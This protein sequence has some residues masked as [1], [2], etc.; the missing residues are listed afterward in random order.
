MNSLTN[1]PALSAPVTFFGEGSYEISAVK[2]IIAT[3]EF[4]TLDE[5]I[6]GCQMKETFESCTTRQ[7]LD[8]VQNQCNCVPYALM[9]S[10]ASSLVSNIMFTLLSCYSIYWLRKQPYKS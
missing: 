10:I 3:E 1:Y 9:K 7:Y 6:R 4:L 5:D 2:K 8:N